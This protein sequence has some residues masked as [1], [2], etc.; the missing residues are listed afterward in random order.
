VTESPHKPGQHLPLPGRAVA[1]TATGVTETSCPGDHSRRAAASPPFGPDGVQVEA[2]Q[3]IG[4]VWSA[5]EGQC[6]GSGRTRRSPVETLRT[7][8]APPVPARDP[9]PIPIST[10]YYLWRR[11]P[12]WRGFSAHPRTP[13]RATEADNERVRKKRQLPLPA[14][15]PEKRS[16]SDRR[17]RR[18]PRRDRG[19]SYLASLTLPLPLR[20]RPLS[21]RRGLTR[22]QKDDACADAV[23]VPRPLGRVGTRRS[24][25]SCEGRGV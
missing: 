1:V 11:D 14:C 9:S 12:A 24:G 25:P 10:R 17:G 22:A 23:C 8:Q 5:D 3:D 21:M 20:L 15:L 19:R 18:A 13:W 6:R 4:S 16:R 2:P 7:P